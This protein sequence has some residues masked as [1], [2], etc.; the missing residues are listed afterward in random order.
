MRLS[1]VVLNAVG[2][3]DFDVGS[4]FMKKKRFIRS[5]RQN[6]W[7]SHGNAWTLYLRKS[8]FTRKIH[9]RLLK[10]K[11]EVNLSE[12]DKKILYEAWALSEEIEKAWIEERKEDKIIESGLAAFA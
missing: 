6:L 12:Y 7:F 1:E 11:T 4:T 2:N 10:G 3:R 8:F 9:A 5:E